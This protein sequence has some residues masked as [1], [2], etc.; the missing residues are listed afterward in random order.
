M[1][2]PE[3]NSFL[4]IAE[5]HMKNISRNFKPYWT[6]TTK[7]EEIHR[8]KNMRH[9]VEFQIPRFDLRNKVFTELWWFQRD[10]FLCL[11]SSWWE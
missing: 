3:F 2:F 1:I 8:K 9:K 5:F 11:F 6:A 10:F 4:Q 7:C